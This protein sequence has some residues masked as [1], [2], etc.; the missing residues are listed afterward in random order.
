MNVSPH[1]RDVELAA[2]YRGLQPG[3]MAI[4]RRKI[5]SVV[6]Q[7]CVWCPEGAAA[8]RRMFVGELDGTYGPGLGD[9]L[10]DCT[11]ATFEGHFSHAMAER[12]R[13][14]WQKAAGSR[15]HDSRKDGHRRAF[16]KECL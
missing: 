15:G 9:E 1:A 7:Y 4:C 2:K 3:Q 5:E 8:N 16:E 10:W 11:T 14:W 6:I 12:N 13:A